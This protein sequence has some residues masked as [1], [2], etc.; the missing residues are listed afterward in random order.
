MPIAPTGAIQPHEPPNQPRTC[1]ED[2]LL[3]AAAQP[4][5][6]LSGPGFPMPG[7]THNHLRADV[8][9]SMFGFFAAAIPGETG[10]VIARF[11]DR[12]HVRAQFAL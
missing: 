8:H 2:A 1:P 7:A 3:V 9:E 6:T 12:V 11:G 5:I 4:L 10:Q